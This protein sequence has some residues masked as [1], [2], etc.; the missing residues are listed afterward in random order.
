MKRRAA[1]TI[2]LLATV[3][4]AVCQDRFIMKKD[5]KADWQL[6]TEESYS[7]YNES[8]SVNTIYFPLNAN[9]YKGDHL[10]VTSDFPFSI[11]INGKLI[12]DRTTNTFLLIDSLSKIVST[13]KLFFAIHQ[14]KDIRRS[15]LSTSVR[16]KEVV[17]VA[18][19]AESFSLKKETFFRD[20]VITIVLILFIFLIST[21]RLN[22][23]LSSDYFSIT[24]IFSLRDTDDDDQLYNRLT[25]GNILFY[26]FTSIVLA[27]FIMVI[28]QFKGIGL[29]LLNT[30][31]YLSSLLTWLKLSAIIFGFLLAKMI[32]IFL[33]S[34]LF[35]VRDISGFHFFNFTRLLL[36]S[37]GILSLV[38]AVYYILHGQQ[39]GFY[40][41]LYEFLLW[42][43]GGWVILLFLKL[44]NRVERSVFHLFSYICAT[45]IIPFL[46][47][48]KV[49]NE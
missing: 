8:E 49:L 36:V 3:F 47:I 23:R 44:T 34:S 21:A 10:V 46:L 1:L 13:S 27:F 16:K 29:S 32:I 24:K 18:E 20:F 11:L 38:I 15:E 12:Q 40:F 17:N 39:K 9:G 14:E 35:G 45:E 19:Q 33:A 6:F 37:I 4:T 28:G 48:V 2:F 42:I 31:G 30:D 26:L 22:P 5:L 43:L 41:F 25:S 7:A